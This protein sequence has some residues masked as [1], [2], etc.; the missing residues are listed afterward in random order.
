MKDFQLID[1]KPIDNS[2]IKRDFT[3]KY[4]KQS[5]QLNQSDQNVQSVF[6][7]NNIYHQIGNGSLEFDITVRKS[8]TKNFHNAD[9]MRLVKIG[10]AFC[11]KEARLSTT[12]GSDIEHKKFLWS[13]IYFYE[14]DNK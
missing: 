4:H 8:D 6:G 13:S 10:F 1:I 5:D 2:I 9:P 11:F 3:K 14:N 7:G 12:F